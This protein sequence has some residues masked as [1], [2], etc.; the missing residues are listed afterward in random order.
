MQSVASADG[1]TRSHRVGRSRLINRSALKRLAILGVII[2]LIL[3]WAWFS[4]IRMPGDSFA[5]PLSALS[6]QQ[7][8]LAEELRSDVTTLA[9]TIGRRNTCYSAGLATAV[10]FLERSLHD[11][12][13]AQ[14]R[15]QTFR[16]MG[17]NVHNIEVEILGESSPQEIV[18]IGA[19][20][21]SV[22]DS[23]AANDNGSGTAAVLALARRFNTR[24]QLPARTLRFVL[25]VN[26]E[27]PSFKTD[28]M[29]SL[30][31]ARACQTRGDDIV[32]M[33]SLETMGY[34]S[35]VPGSQSYPLAP[36]AW[37]YPDTGD[38]IGFVGN[39]GSRRL[40][41]QAIDT[42]R[43]HADFPSE[44]AA[45]PSTIA[46]VDWSD[47]WAFW[48]CGYPAIMVTDSAIFRY[49]HYHRTTDTPDKL[50][51][52]RLARVVNG[53]E[54]VVADLVRLARRE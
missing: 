29:G 41:R 49:P 11:A 7:A 46:G 30:V 36:I 52:P 25:F 42:F 51:Y 8:A 33:L 40:V 43:R 34:Y 9:G 45:L 26:E 37:L 4:M 18:V 14:V 2:A 21:D 6:D 16:S 20:Y 27:P 31:Y 53:L 50:D 32:A 12:G 15:R 35:D 3:A 10:T 47:H 5:G 22:D 38:F 1:V 48:Q 23:P 17:I 54:A 39:Y 28:D 24:T 13:Y 44:G 19:H